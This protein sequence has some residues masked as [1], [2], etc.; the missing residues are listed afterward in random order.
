ML[1]SVIGIEIMSKKIYSA[2]E[3]NLNRQMLDKDALET[4]EILNKHKHSAYIVGGGVR[5][6]LLAKKPKDFDIVTSATPEQVKK[7]FGHKAIIIGRR[8]KIVHVHFSKLNEERSA[9]LGKKVHDRHILEVSTFRSNKIIDDNLSNHGRIL[10][11][12]NYGTM[13]EDAFRRDFTIN[14]LYYDPINEKIYDY[15]NGIADIKN[16]LLRI[17]GKPQD[18]YIEDPVRILRAIRISEKL[19]LTIDDNTFIPFK[20]TKQLLVN[21]PR[22]RLFEEM[23]KLLVSGSSLSVIND[24]ID[25]RLPRK[26]FPILD[27]LFLQQHSEISK[28]VL[29]KTDLRISNGED[30]SVLY[31]FAA[32]MWESIYNSWTRDLDL[33]HSSKKQALFDAISYNKSI[34]FDSG[35]TQNMYSSMREIWLLQYDFE[36]PNLNKL[37]N[38]LKHGRFRQ[39]WHLLALRHEFNQVDPQIYEWWNKFINDETAD[40]TQL[41][42]ELVDLSPV[43]EVKK[44]RKRKKRKKINHSKQETHN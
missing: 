43:S 12:N 20:S 42:I 10:V 32:L 7:V 40:K 14:A 26:V 41:L 19:G 24:L 6:L 27:R 22:G 4:I 35:I 34:L 39:A 28:R 5:D 16:K 33:F 9:K 29:E 13:D 44:K 8:F 17:I 23:I 37:D 36:H 11:D 31:V 21:E 15:H 3:L 18:R 1:F 38:L 2:L 30:V 25:L